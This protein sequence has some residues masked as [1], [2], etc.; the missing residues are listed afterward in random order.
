MS[1]G[2]VKLFEI[3]NVEQSDAKRR[4]SALSACDLRRDGF[5]ES[6]AVECAGELVV[7]DEGACIVQFVN[8][9]FGII[10]PLFG[11]A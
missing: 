3:I 6:A 11:G 7:A 9:L 10:N 1:E 4:S 8:A 5:F 2:V